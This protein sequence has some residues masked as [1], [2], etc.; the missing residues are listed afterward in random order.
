MKLFLIKVFLITF[1]VFLNHAQAKNFVAQYSVSTS[2]I[3]IGKF[4]WLLKTEE[5]NY[6]TKINLKSSGVF[7]S[8]YKFEGEYLSRGIINDK[9]FETRQ[10]KQYWKTKKKTKIVEMIFDEYLKKLI[11]KPK[12]RELSRINLDEL[13]GYYDPITSFLNILSGSSYAKTIDGRRVYIMKRSNILDL[14]SL[15]L[16]IKEYK[17][18]WADHKRND[19]EKIE[20]FLSQDSFLPVKINVYFK[21]RVFKLQKN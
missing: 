17:N 15:V 11:Q 10:Y 16:E 19:L 3:K 12:E 6:E 2:G 20:F 7:S 9:N 4:V 8:L 14:K 21:N 13:S 1:F 18:I 5:N